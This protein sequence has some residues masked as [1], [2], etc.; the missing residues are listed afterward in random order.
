MSSFHRIE[1]AALRERLDGENAPLVLDAR[2]RD[3]FVQLPQAIAGAIPLLLDAQP[4]ELP[5][6]PRHQAIVV[7]CL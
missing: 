4:L 6:L 1:P 7:Y 2:R 5:D 3:A